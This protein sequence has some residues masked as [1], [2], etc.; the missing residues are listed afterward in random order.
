MGKSKPTFENTSPLL[1]IIHVVPTKCTYNQQTYIVLFRGIHSN[2]FFGLKNQVQEGKS[3]Q[4]SVGYTSSSNSRIRVYWILQLAIITLIAP[5]EG[6]LVFVHLS[7]LKLRLKYHF[8]AL[9]KCTLLIACCNI[10]YIQYMCV[11]VLRREYWM[12]MYTYVHIFLCTSFFLKMAHLTHWGRGHLNC[13][14]ARS[15][16]F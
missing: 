12:M 8:P 2:T 14:N 3:I 1:F 5:Y 11:C 10:I 13:L 15:R 16:G 6:P 9:N 4:I 7:L